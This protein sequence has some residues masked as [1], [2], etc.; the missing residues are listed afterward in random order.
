MC[1]G[2]PGLFPQALLSSFLAPFMLWALSE[3]LSHADM[4][5]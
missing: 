2:V 3:H 1:F 5:Q 4:A